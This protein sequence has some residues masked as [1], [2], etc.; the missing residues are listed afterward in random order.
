MPTAPAP[1][2]IG[3]CLSLTG[4]LAGNSQS[5][6][7]A[8]DI[9]REDVNNRG[10]LLGRPVELICYDDQ[11]DVSRVP[12]LY[13]RLMDEDQVD[14]VIGGYGTN[15]LLPAMPVIIERERFFVG[16]MG[17][18]VNNTFAYPNYFA[19][20]PTGPDPNAALT[21]GFFALAAEQRPRPATVALVSADAEFSRNPI[22]GAKANAEKYGFRIVHEA[23]YPLTTENFTPVIDAISESN[24]DL[25]FLCSY[26]QDSIGLVCAIHAHPFRPKMV[27]GGMIGPQNTAVKTTLGPRLNGFVNYEYWAP[28]PKMIFP[29]VQELRNTYQARA[30]DA[31]IDLLGHYMAPLA[32]AQMQVVAQAV[33]ATR[34]FDDASLS[35]FAQSATFNTVMDAIRFGVKGE[36]VEPRVLQVQ[37]QGISGHEVGQFRNGSRQIVVSPPNFTS[38]ELS[39]PYAEALS[40]EEGG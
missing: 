13:K 30:S 18:G 33:E 5:A 12:G 16:L 27:G 39:F 4:P 19:M 17:L 26:L 6:R 22:L 40:A 15:T 20:I 34:G 28:V 32:Y 23:T 38:G 8:H 25:L 1:I 2:R 29:G 37:F 7:L 36:W 11:A 24:C 14:L 3:Y 31:G 10:G 9:W 35:A 21:E